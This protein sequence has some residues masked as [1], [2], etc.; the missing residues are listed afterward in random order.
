MKE[1][2]Q[3]E[4]LQ[5]QLG[6][7]DQVTNIG[8]D[9]DRSINTITPSSQHQNT[10]TEMHTSVPVSQGTVEHVSQN[11]VSLLLELEQMKAACTSL[12]GLYEGLKLE[13]DAFENRLAHANAELE[14][15]FHRKVLTKSFASFYPPC[16]EEF[17]K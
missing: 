16:V 2:E 6:G 4:I 7:L 9:G 17:N 5:K 13:R 10:F 1:R 3:K 15:V 8:I 11:N 14:E 12:K